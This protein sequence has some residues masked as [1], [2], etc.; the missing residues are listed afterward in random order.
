VLAVIGVVTSPDVPLLISESR[1][2]VTAAGYRHCFEVTTTLG[3][4]PHRLPVDDNSTRSSVPLAG[5]SNIARASVV[6]VEGPPPPNAFQT[7]WF[8]ASVPVA[9]DRSTG[10]VGLSSGGDAVNLFDAVGL[11]SQA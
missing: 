9:S 10:G 6:F 11:G 2:G 5:V 7:A 8:G 3:R 4:R 1:R